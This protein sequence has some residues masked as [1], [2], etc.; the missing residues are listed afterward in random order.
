ME[1][2]KRCEERLLAGMIYD[3]HTR[4]CRL[5]QLTEESFIDFNHK[6][7]FSI[8][9]EMQNRTQNDIIFKINN[10]N[11]FLHDFDYEKF[12]D[13]ID[14]EG[15]FCLSD[16]FYEEVKKFERYRMVQTLFKAIDPKDPQKHQ[17]DALLQAI[18]SSNDIEEE[19]NSIKNGLIAVATELMTNKREPSLMSGFKEFDFLIDGMRN[20]VY[21]MCGRPGMGKT[22]F[23]F[24]VA[25]ETSRANPHIEVLF[26]SLEMSLRDCNYKTA[27]Y[28]TEIPRNR[29][30]NSI[31]SKK[32][33]GNSEMNRSDQD[34][35]VE[36]A[37]SMHN[38]M[39]IYDISAINCNQIENI[40]KHHEE[41]SG[42]K[43]G[44]IVIDYIQIMSANNP[45]IINETER[46]QAISHEVRQL[47][48][49]N[50]PVLA[51]A[52]LNRN[53]NSTEK[54]K[55]GDLKSSSQLEQ[56]ATAVFVLWQENESVDLVKGG[57]IKNRYGKNE[58]FIDFFFNKKKSKFFP[59]LENDIELRQAEQDKQWQAE[60]EL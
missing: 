34:L 5:S 21:L 51:L 47:A 25:Y 54:P 59:Y 11:L 20:G 1:E 9:R 10:S 42:K 43:V 49:K 4:A 50:F 12:C 19:S 23:A 46:I 48:K 33:H 53:V 30:E 22:T 13:L 7:I 37:N 58:E 17:I 14:L 52:Q 32:E 60:Q 38:N 55:L 44:M 2:L 40:V 8:I 35:F 41:R 39:V 45:K 26:F 15:A 16:M 29:L 36:A 3:N 31:R 57:V 24:Q 18:E 56:D 28:F 6:V 27:T